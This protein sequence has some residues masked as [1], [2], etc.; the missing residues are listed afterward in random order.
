[1]LRLVEAVGPAQA[2][3]R[4]AGEVPDH[5]DSG[6]EG[7]EVGL[8]QVLLD[9]TEPRVG[10]RIGDVR[11]LE[12]DVVVVG[13]AVD[14]DH[15]VALRQEAVDEGASD[16]SGGAGDDHVHR[17]I[18]TGDR[19]MSISGSPGWSDGLLWSAQVPRT[20]TSALQSN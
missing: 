5:V 6:E 1:M 10:E 13:E 16:E 14:A 15:V 8:E 3:A 7:V 11:P 20:V 4:L 18:V 9:E 19:R 17:S 12:G 2:Y